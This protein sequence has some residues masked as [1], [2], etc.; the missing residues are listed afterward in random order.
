MSFEDHGDWNLVGRGHALVDQG[1]LFSSLFKLNLD[2]SGE[3]EAPYPA[4]S[5][6]TPEIEA[7]PALVP[8]VSASEASR[9]VRFQVCSVY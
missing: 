2:P 4:R 5:L 1:A 9:W 6:G 3:Q 8:D 7:L